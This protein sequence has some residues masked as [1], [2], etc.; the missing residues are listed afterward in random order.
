MNEKNQIL[1]EVKDSGIGMELEHIEN[2]GNPFI[3]GKKLENSYGSGLGLYI[4]TQ[5]LKQLDSE[6]IC[7]SI[8][9]KGTSLSFILSNTIYLD[10][11]KYSSTGSSKSVV[12]SIITRK[13][14]DDEITPIDP[15]QIMEARNILRKNSNKNSV[16]KNKCN[17]FT[18]QLVRSTENLLSNLRCS[19]F[20]VVDDEKFTRQSTLRILRNTAYKLNLNFIYIEA[21]DGME[22]LSFVYEMLKEGKKISGIISDEMM[23]HMN[24]STTAEIF[25]KIK[26]FN[27]Q[28]I[29]FY[30]LTALTDFSNSYVDFC[31]SKPLIEK[32][33]LRILQNNNL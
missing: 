32:E 15:V 19:Y 23:N 26:N 3:K 4:V 14:K 10:T 1:F 28:L 27:T 2:I 33:A 21:E 11:C 31:I 12:S 22:C 18:T 16:T 29:P 24:G 7:N 20:I 9:G 13:I 8:I 6:L 5:L 30:L 17:K 25:K